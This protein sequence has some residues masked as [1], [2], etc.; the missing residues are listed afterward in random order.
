MEK[1]SKYLQDYLGLSPGVQNKLIATLV[2]IFIL[3]FIRRFILWFSK[4]KFNDVQIIY[5]WRKT[6]L[7]IVFSIGFILVGR[8]WFEGFGS[9]A[10]YFGLLSAGL[11]IALNQPVANLAGWA[12]IIWRKPFT[13]GDRIEINHI[14]GDVIDIRIFQFTMMEIGNWVDADQSTGRIVHVPNGKIFNEW[15]ANYSVGFAYIWNEVSVLVTFESNWRKAKEILGKIV[16]ARAEHRSEGAEEQIRETS[17]RFLIFNDTLEPSV[18]TSVRES[19]VLITIRYLCAP[20]KRRITEHEIWEDVLTEFAKCNDIDFA[21]PT[22]RFY[23][24]ITEGKENA[25]ANNVGETE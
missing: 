25:R 23:K 7:Y 17:K 21:Y 20:R 24:N 6:S 1:I 3:W 16:I 4:K 8:I 9:I 19:G 14:T 13:V 12:F 5:R 18:Y 22:T 10:T 11:A 2:A 15:L